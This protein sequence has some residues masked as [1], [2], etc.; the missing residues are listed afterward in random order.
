MFLGAACTGKPTE[1][2]FPVRDGKTSTE[3]RV[4]RKNMHRAVTICET[5][6]ACSECLLYSLENHEIGIWGGIGEKSRK[7]A[8][9][10]LKQGIGIE[11][12]RARLMGS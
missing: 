11:E 2:W 12:I 5:C 4:I 10:M 8:R 1:W 9:R 6:P 7:R 3:L